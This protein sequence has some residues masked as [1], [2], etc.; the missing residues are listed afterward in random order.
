MK[1]KKGKIPSDFRR[2]YL[3]IRSYY[4]KKILT[5]SIIGS[6]YEIQSSILTPHGCLI[7]NLPSELL[8]FA[9]KIQYSASR[10][11]SFLISDSETVSNS[12]QFI[13]KFLHSSLLNKI[14]S[15]FTQRH[16]NEDDEEEKEEL[17]HKFSSSFTSAYPYKIK[18][19]PLLNNRV[20]NV[21]GH[22]NKR[23]FTDGN[24]NDEYNL[25][26]IEK[27]ILPLLKEEILLY[28]YQGG[29]Y[30][31]SYFKQFFLNLF[32]FFNI[33]ND[34]SSFLSKNYHL[35]NNFTSSSSFINNYSCA[36]IRSRG[37]FP[38]LFSHKASGN[39]TKSTAILTSNTFYYIKLNNKSS[40]IFTG[41]D[42]KLKPSA[43]SPSS[44]NNLLGHMSIMWCQLL[45]PIKKK[46]KINSFFLV[47]LPIQEVRHTNLI[48][49]NKG[50]VPLNYNYEDTE[51]KLSCCQQAPYS[52]SSYYLLQIYSSLGLIFPLGEDVPFHDWSNDGRLKRFE[53]A[54]G[55]IQTHSYA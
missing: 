55:V 7:L 5:G 30:K 33:F 28:R 52:H 6:D 29:Y 23:Q 2:V 10:S 13:E 53:G 14:N 27:E 34:F 49:I 51:K 25:S 9:K 36:Y 47:W 3:A 35:F 31:I 19:D 1:E 40:E 50:S 38:F 20:Y 46:F 12:G 21:L 42:T 4:P 44:F 17:L 54:L 24:I 15:D 39:L 18:N 22:I 45:A 43:S 41:Q 16:E 37:C 8:A 48:Q 26:L 32:S 11:N